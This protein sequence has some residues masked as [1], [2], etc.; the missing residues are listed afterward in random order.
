MPI[1]GMRTT[2]NFVT[3]QRP[4]NWRETIALMY[5]NSGRVRQAPLTALTS[6]MKKRK[7]DDPVF[8]WW[9]KS[10]NNRRFLITANVAAS[11]ANAAGSLTV[12]ATYNAATGLKKND[13]IFIEQTGEVAR[14]SSDPTATNTIPL[15]RGVATGGSG[16]AI[17]DIAGAGVNPYAMVIGSAFEEGSDA[18]TGV[19]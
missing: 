5:P 13:L 14:V 9:D 2:A 1:L 7:V 18:P 8:H 16:L 6:V 4:E 3:N 19:N 11:A 17:A 10:L 15:V 12:D